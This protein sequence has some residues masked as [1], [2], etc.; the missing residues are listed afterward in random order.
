[1]LFLTVID[2]SSIEETRDKP[3]GDASVLSARKLP[4]RNIWQYQD[5]LNSDVDGF[6]HPPPP[7]T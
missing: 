2:V 3:R 1:M 6:K 7:P 4:F 5:V